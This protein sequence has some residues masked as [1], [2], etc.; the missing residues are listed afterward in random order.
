[1]YIFGG[2]VNGDRAN[3]VFRFD[4]QKQEWKQIEA[5]K[6]MP[7]ARA[8]HSACVIADAGQDAYMYIFGGKD[9]DDKILNDMWRLNL[10]TN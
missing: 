5:S 1:M 7:A 10:S 2:F 9:N 8:G 6:K 4:F 3:E